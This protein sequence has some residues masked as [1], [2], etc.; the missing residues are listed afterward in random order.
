M[1]ILHNLCL[2]FERQDGQDRKKP[3]RKSRNYVKW[4]KYQKPKEENIRDEHNINHG[5]Y[6]PGL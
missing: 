5:I 3:E 6:E 2:H 1:K 4:P